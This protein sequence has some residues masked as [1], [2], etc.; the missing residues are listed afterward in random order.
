MTSAASS[1]A[2]SA[3]EEQQVLP[4]WLASFG[5]AEHERF[6]ASLCRSTP[7]RDA[8]LMIAWLLDT[9]P[10][11]ATGVAW[12]QVPPSLRAGSPCVVAAARPA[13][14]GTLG[15]GD[16]RRVRSTSPCRSP[17]EPR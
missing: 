4:M 14:F 17:G 12:N 15:T 2:T 10:D 9:A 3:L 8:G 5:V 13:G 11:G 1:S 16:R 6:A 7:L